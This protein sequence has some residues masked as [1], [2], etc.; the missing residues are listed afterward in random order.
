MQDRIETSR[1]ILRPFEPSDVE[2]AFG[3]FGDPVVMRFAP[4]GHDK[5]IEETKAKLRFFME[6][7]KTHGFSK[8]LILD[9]DSGTSPSCYH[10]NTPPC[11]GQRE[12][13]C[14]IEWHCWVRFFPMGKIK[15]VLWLTVAVFA[16]STTFQ[17]GSAYIGNLELHEDLRDVAANISARIGLSA[18][19]T[20]EDLRS[21]VIAKAQVH[22]ITLL[23]EQVTVKVTG[24]GKTASIY[25]QVDYA[26]RINLLVYSFP[27]HLRTSNAE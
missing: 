18:P 6:H 10:T 26:A 13:N 24:E 22:D 23:P 4:M 25:M 19:P 17:I 21:F 5:R 27:L 7:Q 2:A 12:H 1:L 15:V 3:W 14:T 8:W 11:L 16:I 20:N 9:R